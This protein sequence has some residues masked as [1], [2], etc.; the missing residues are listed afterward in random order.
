MK[1]GG[2]VQL[3][4]IKE[5]KTRVIIEV[6]GAVVLPACKPTTFWPMSLRRALK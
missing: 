4:A 6:A 1:E 3:L 2:L 5:V